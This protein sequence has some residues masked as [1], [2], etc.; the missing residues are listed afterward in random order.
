MN[1]SCSFSRREGRTEWNGM[2]VLCEPKT[3]IL[4]I[5]ALQGGCAS[6]GSSLAGHVQEGMDEKIEGRGGDQT[7]CPRCPKNIETFE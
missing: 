4:R 2:D 3:F 7:L 5:N 1:P 6:S